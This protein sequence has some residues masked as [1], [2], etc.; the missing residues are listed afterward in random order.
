MAMT[1]KKNKTAR[2]DRIRKVKAG[3]QKYYGNS[4]LVLAGTS[5]TPANLQAFLQGDIDANDASMQAKAAWLDT[6]TIAKAN[7]AKV[8]PVLRAI[9]A[10]VQ[11]QYGEA[12]NA[13]TVLADFGYSPR[14]KVAKSA[15]TKARAAKQSLAT[16][17]ARH[18]MGPRQRAKV[19]G[20]LPDASAPGAT[21]SAGTG[22]PVVSGTP[23]HGSGTQ[24]APAAPAAPAPN[25][26]TSSSSHS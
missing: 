25:G 1:G 13:E 4:N 6:V 26:T 20:V 12:Q 21:A 23:D 8:D 24:T 5:F 22:S 19:K 16:R 10:M 11:S 3:L 15:E 18:T 2:A 17:E 7:D 14:K 9:H